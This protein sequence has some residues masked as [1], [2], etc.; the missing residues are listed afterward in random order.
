[1][2]RAEAKAQGLNR[3]ISKF[4][5]HGHLSKRYTCNG[6]CVECAHQMRK[7]KYMRRR[8]FWNEERLDYVT[9]AYLRGD[10]HKLIAEALG[11]TRNTIIGKTYRLGLCGHAATQRSNS[12]LLPRT[13]KLQRQRM[14]V[15][16]TTDPEPDLT[17]ENIKV[18]QQSILP[19]LARVK[20]FV[21]ASAPNYHINH[22]V[23][24]CQWENCSAAVARGSY[25]LEH[26]AIVYVDR[27]RDRVKRT[28]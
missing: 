24:I 15:L 20:E 18:E 2:T 28:F 3:Y 10:S 16:F 11:T 27:D 9:R 17:N 14:L 7:N 6:R 21:T 22:G 4:C 13:P 1:M 25:C 23:S 5:K 26:G 12:G 8:T 19:K